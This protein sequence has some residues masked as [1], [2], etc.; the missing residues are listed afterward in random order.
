MTDNESKIPAAPPRQRPAPSSQAV[1]L[2]EEEKEHKR[3]EIVNSAPLQTNP[4]DA[5]NPPG[6]DKPKR[7]TKPKV[8]P[9]RQGFDLPV[10]KLLLMPV[11]TTLSTNKEIELR[12]AFIASEMNLNRGFGPK[13]FLRDLQM[14]AFDE[15][16]TR[17]LKEMG[18]DVD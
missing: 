6:E 14:Q 7:S 9:W 3:Q 10:E 17:K 13:V 1:Q 8:K 16:T 11:K 18:Y 4:D 12:L 15:F 5:T 2:T